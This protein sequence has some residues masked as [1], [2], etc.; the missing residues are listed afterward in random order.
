[1]IGVDED[2]RTELRVLSGHL[3]RAR[4]RLDPQSEEDDA[5]SELKDDTCRQ[6]EANQLAIDC[7]KPSVPS[8]DRPP[9]RRQSRG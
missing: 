6:D 4:L 3:E 5:E 8:L 1:M 2:A 7:T 9:R